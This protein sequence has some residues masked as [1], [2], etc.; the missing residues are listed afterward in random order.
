MLRL[1]NSNILDDAGAKKAC[2]MVGLVPNKGNIQ[3]VVRGFDIE[4]RGHVR[5]DHFAPPNERCY[6]VRSQG[7]WADTA[8]RTYSVYVNSKFL[9]CTCPQYRTLLAKSDPSP[10]VT[11]VLCK[12]GAAVLLHEKR[13]STS[14]AWKLIFSFDEDDQ[15]YLQWRD[16]R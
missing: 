14:F 6:H 16:E 9:Y 7:I 8:D 11:D 2:T 3:T 1:L 10:I 4:S 15:N 12:H 5:F 13:P